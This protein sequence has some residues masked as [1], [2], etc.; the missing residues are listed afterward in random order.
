LFIAGY[1]LLYVIPESAS[2]GKK[3]RQ[4]NRQTEE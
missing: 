1:V 2:H 3:P 4:K